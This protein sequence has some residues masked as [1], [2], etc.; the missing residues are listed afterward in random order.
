M[1]VALSVIPGI[2]FN[3]N[4]DNDAGEDEPWDSDLAIAG[5]GRVDEM[6]DAA[7]SAATRKM[8]TW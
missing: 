7:G 5:M 2:L 6:E 1:L 8:Y 3:D 4:K